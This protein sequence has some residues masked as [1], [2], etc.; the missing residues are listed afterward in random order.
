MAADEIRVGDVGTV[1]SLTISDGSA[2]VDI[3]SAT[4]KQILFQKPDGTK[5]TKDANFATDG[6]DGI[7]TYA[8]IAGDLD[9][10]GYWQIQ[11]YIVMPA[12]TWKSDINR[13]L[14][15]SNL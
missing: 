12:G 4:T 1:F 8:A 2:A 14:V 11:A 7:I 5:L 6:S 9:S 3:S 10:A 15:H 13:F